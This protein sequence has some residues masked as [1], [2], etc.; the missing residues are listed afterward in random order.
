VSL[1]LWPWPFN[2]KNHVTFSISQ[3]PFSFS[4]GGGV[5]VSLTHQRWGLLNAGPMRNPRDVCVVL[6]G[7]HRCHRWGVYVCV[8]LPSTLSGPGS[9][10]SLEREVGCV[11]LWE[12]GWETWNQLFIDWWARARCFFM[13]AY[14]PSV[15]TDV[16][17]RPQHTLASLARAKLS[18]VREPT[19]RYRQPAGTHSWEYTVCY[20]R[21]TSRL[22][23]E[24]LWTHH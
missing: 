3:G 20:H 12:R 13:Y 11:G 19:G 23:N 10:C 9:S 24:R 2:P 5:R 16:P 6:C 1:S 15:H 7:S 8:A 22:I 18:D 21:L 4:S 17:P 14:I